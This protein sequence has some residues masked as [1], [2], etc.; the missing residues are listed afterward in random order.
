[1]RITSK[2]NGNDDKKWNQ[3]IKGDNPFLGTGDDR[4]F[5]IRIYCDK[6]GYKVFA[7]NTLFANAIYRY[8]YSKVKLTE[9]NSFSVSV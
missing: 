2:D 6:S 1:M 4:F 9:A 8:D 3:E 5:E 7:S